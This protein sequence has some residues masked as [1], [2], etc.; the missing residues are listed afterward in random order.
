MAD[1]KEE[2]S[3]LT[4]ENKD[5]F[6]FID[7]LKTFVPLLGIFGAFCYI[8]GRSYIES[9][10]GSLGMTADVLAFDTND[11]MFFSTTVV[12]LCLF[13]SLLFFL[14]W[15]FSRRGKS[16]VF[17]EHILHKES[18][19]DKK[20]K[21]KVYVIAPLIVILLIAS[22]VYLYLSA[23]NENI[24][25]D[26]LLF[27]CSAL[28]LLF[29]LIIITDLIQCTSYLTWHKNLKDSSAYRVISAIF[30]GIIVFL[31]TIV[32]VDIL[33]K[34]QANSDSLLFPKVRIISHSDFPALMQ[35]DTSS[36]TD[37]IDGQLITTNNGFTYVMKR[38][39]VS[40]NADCR[41]IEIKAATETVALAEVIA[42]I[43]EDKICRLIYAIPVDSIQDIIYYSER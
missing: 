33:A 12:I 36:P 24:K 31:L 23:G 1:K 11:Y 3:K 4:A 15:E 25:N 40:A 34:S 7:I 30:I 21:L 41:A 38:F 42:D 13:I 37:Y 18:V 35:S 39:K 20:T 28:I 17:D 14:Y 2:K 22:M 16:L 8:L 43:G 10:Y 6:N 9:Y 19:I 32:P 27:I 5:D 26:V 29:G